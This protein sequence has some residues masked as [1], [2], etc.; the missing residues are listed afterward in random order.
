[1]H[2]LTRGE[3]SQHDFP[4]AAAAD[5][6]LYVAWTTYHNEANTVYLRSEPAAHGGTFRATDGWG[7]FYGTRARCRR[8]RED[9][10]V[11]ERIPLR[12]LASGQPRLRS[13]R[14]ALGGRALRRARRRQTIL[15]Q[16]RH[17]RGRT[18][19]GCLAGVHRGRPR[20]HDRFLFR[21]QMVAARAGQSVGRA[22]DWAPAI[23]AA[24]DGAVW[25]AWDGYD[26]GNYDIFMRRLDADGAGPVIAAAQNGAARDRAVDRRGRR[27]TPLGRPGPR[28][29]S[30][31]GQGL[32]RSGAGPAR[33]SALRARTPLGALRRRQVDRAQR[34]AARK[35][36][37]CLDVRDARVP[38]IWRSAARPAA[39]SVLSER[40]SCGIRWKTTS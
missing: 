7:D 3:A 29:R 31:L 20:H 26:A 4:A 22:N 18:A 13:G 34:R 6:A 2:A 33:N 17:C 35:R 8:G 24:P 10:R 14:R 11:L 25:I 15:P 38:R 37:A 16:K 21:G 36:R 12:P 28:A 32:G 39:V 27:R 5:G 30:E 19:V 1:M 40:C 9:P 23:A